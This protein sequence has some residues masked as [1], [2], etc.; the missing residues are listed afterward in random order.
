[1]RLFII[2]GK[3]SLF[4]PAP[5]DQAKEFG[6]SFCLTESAY[7]NGERVT[8]QHR[9][10]V[11]PAQASYTKRQAEGNFL[12]SVQAAEVYQM[13]NAEGKAIADTFVMKATRIEGV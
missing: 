4:V 7:L 1:M 11:T 10:Y 8:C 13:R 3:A 9:V 2:T 6:G 5:P 12:V